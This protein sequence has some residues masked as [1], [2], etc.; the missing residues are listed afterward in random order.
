MALY[1]GDCLKRTLFLTTGACNPHGTVPIHVKRFSPGG[2]VV[3]M[4]K[5][6]IVS[7]GYIR[8]GWACKAATSPWAAKAAK[9]VT[10]PLRV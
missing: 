2:I 5:F 4:C 1:I 6:V 7:P 10:R 9:W 8:A 3:P